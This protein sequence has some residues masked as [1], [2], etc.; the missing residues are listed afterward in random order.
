M[1][2]REELAEAI[3]CAIRTAGRAT[4]FEGGAKIVCDA[5]RLAARLQE[6]VAWISNVALES[7]KRGE[8]AT[9]RGRAGLYPN[10][11]ALYAAASSS[12]SPEPSPFLYGITGTDGITRKVT[13]ASPSPE[14]DWKQDQAET[15]RLPRK[16]L[17][18]SP[19]S[20]EREG[21]RDI[22]IELVDAASRMP[23]ETPAA[24][25][26]GTEHNFSI[27]A[28]T[29]WVLDA[30]LKKASAALSRSEAV[31]VVEEI[32]NSARP[33]DE[34]K[35]R[36]VS[37]TSGSRQ[38]ATIAAN[39]L[40]EHHGS[41]SEAGMG[42]ERSSLAEAPSS[43]ADS[44]RESIIMECVDIAEKYGDCSGNYG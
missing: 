2:E 14:P 3:E 31:A 27:E 24:G 41:A 30:V 43:P 20:A 25:G 39:S 33:T 29:V 42:S 15:S 32:Q 21:L 4:I 37:A 5:L 13:T 12:P 26:A 23:R 6:P 34:A 19:V 38:S 18:P 17:S 11:V 22:L 28:A 16:P 1:S 10:E 7:L 9:A 35:A 8:N 40:C 44:V 36:D